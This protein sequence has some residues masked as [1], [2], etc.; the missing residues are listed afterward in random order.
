M[1]F[2]IT[3][4][5]AERGDDAQLTASIRELA[6]GDSTPVGP[7][8]AYWG[9]LL[10]RTNERID[11]ATSPK[12]LTISWAL[13]V[14]LPG[15]LAIASFMI[16]LRYFVPMETRRALPLQAVVLSLPEAEMDTMLAYPS[17]L[18]EGLSLAD[19]EVDPF[20]VQKE[21]LQEYLI[22][23]ASV[24]SMTETLDD[25]QVTDVLTVLGSRTI[26]HT[27]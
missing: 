13:R 14:A 19:L 20:A 1:R 15:V 10:A 4:R 7:A 12:A 8:G 11:E 25:D 24:A 27:P 26:D 21:D 16:G 3:T 6:S 22:A 5:P 18:N 9:A 2:R 23:S 17:R